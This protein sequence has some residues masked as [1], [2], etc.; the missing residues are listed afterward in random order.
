MESRASAEHEPTGTNAP[1]EGAPVEPMNVATVDRL[2]HQLV[3]RI[4][5][6]AAEERVLQAMEGLY[7]EASKSEAA[8]DEVLRMLVR[9]G[10]EA[11]CKERFGGGKDVSEAFVSVARSLGLDPRLWWGQA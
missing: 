5:N 2:V 8:R 1:A 6:G 7:H 4:K 11:A 9:A 10:I 3:G